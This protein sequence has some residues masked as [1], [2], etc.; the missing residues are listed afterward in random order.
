MRRGTKIALVVLTLLLA[1]A[2]T[3]QLL[4]ASQDRPPYPVPSTATP[5]P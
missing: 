2:A 1:G 4:L 3:W 5:T